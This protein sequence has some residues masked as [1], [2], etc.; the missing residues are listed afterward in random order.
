MSP[1]RRSK[2]KLENAILELAENVKWRRVPQA[3][4]T[5]DDLIEQLETIPL[6]EKGFHALVAYCA[7]SIDFYGPHLVPVEKA[8]ERAQQ[9]SAWNLTL[10]DLAFLNTAEG[11]VK[12][13]RDEYRKAEAFFAQVYEDSRRGGYIELT[14]VSRYYQGRVSWKQGDYNQALEHIREAKAFDQGSNNHSRVASMELDE[15]WLLFLTGKVSEAKQVLDHAKSLLQ[16]SRLDNPIDLGNILSFQGRLYR[17]ERQYEKALECSNEAI[18]A[19]GE[20]DP[21]HRNVARCHINNGFVYRLLARDLDR[22]RV[23]PALRTKTE[24]QVNALRQKAFEELAQADEIFR[25]D[26]KRNARRLGK[27]HSIRALLFLDLCE[28]DTAEAEACLAFT[29]AESKNDKLVMADARIIQSTLALEGGKGSNARKAF[30]F[31]QQGIEL[32]E[33][34]Q[35]RRLRARAYIRQGLAL[36]EFPY[37]DALG[38]RACYQE[39]QTYLVPEDKDYLRDTFAGLAKGIERKLSVS[40]FVYRITR[41]DMEKYH[42]DG[43]TLEEISAERDEELIRYVYLNSDRSIK[44]TANKLK[45]GEKKVRRALQTFKISE[46]TLKHLSRETIGD[47]I[48]EKIAGLRG[49]EIQGQAVFLSQLKKVLREDYSPELISKILNY[50]HQEIHQFDVVVTGGPNWPESPPCK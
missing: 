50:T 12:F 48:V 2:I 18:V 23:P 27:L 11:L 47:S 36:L 30:E 39:A 40:T 20:H 25:F 3:L 31:A 35:D 13:H 5:V 34:T 32:A 21:G 45:T 19:Y 16:N 1:Q 17:E 8:L 15:G 24:E 7:W 37:D 6:T 46:V 33:Q 26:E 43:Y 9:I 14:T 41:A 28:F 49:R 4:A 42:L 10:C 44:K 29:L 38:A 22:K